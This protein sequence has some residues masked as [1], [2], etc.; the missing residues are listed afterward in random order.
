MMMI[1]MEAVKTAFAVCGVY[2]ATYWFM[3]FVLWLDKPK[4]GRR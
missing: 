3:R 4:R 2:F 1:D